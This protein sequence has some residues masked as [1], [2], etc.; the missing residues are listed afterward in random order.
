MERSVWRDGI[1][2]LGVMLA[3]CGGLLLGHGQ[4][5]AQVPGLDVGIGAVGYFGGNFLDEPDDKIIEDNGRQLG[6]IYPGFGGTAAG[7]G[8]LL[9]ARYAGIVGIETGLLFVQGEG[10][11]DIND[12]DITLK[13][14]ELHIPL[15]LKLSAPTPVVSPNIFG[16]LEFVVPLESKAEQELQL[17]P[18][19]V[20][21]FAKGYKLLSFGL[22]MEFALPIVGVDIRIPLALRGGYNLDD[23]GK[24]EDRA[25]YNIQGNLIRSMEFNAAWQWHAS[26]TLGVMYYF[27]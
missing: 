12:V 17:A 18:D 7:G 24:I 26:A 4:A 11:G 10:K 14:Q 13:T 15:L 9:D 3:L 5:Q 2:A 21:A 20:S 25:R 1:G 27:M 19:G 6:V 22:G 16:G 23:T 8:L